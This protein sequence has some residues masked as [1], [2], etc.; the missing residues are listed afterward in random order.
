MTASR[1]SFEKAKDLA[2][3]RRKLTRSHHLSAKIIFSHILRT[4]RKHNPVFEM[5]QQELG[6]ATLYTRKTVGVALQSLCNSGDLEKVST[7]KQER[8]GKIASYRVPVMDEKYYKSRG[9]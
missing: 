5:G 1:I 7:Q 6:E 3:D 9:L 2:R 4:L 8:T